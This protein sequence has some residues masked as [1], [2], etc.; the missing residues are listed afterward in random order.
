MALII[1][2]GSVL[3]LGVA[4]P[5]SADVSIG[6]ILTLEDAQRFHQDVQEL[7]PDDAQLRIGGYRPTKWVRGIEVSD[8]T[9]AALGS[10][11]VFGPPSQEHKNGRVL[12]ELRLLID[13]RGADAEWERFGVKVEALQ[14]NDVD[15]SALRKKVIA[16][17][18]DM[19]KDARPIH[20]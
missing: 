19:Q 17:L 11:K 8:R 10:W 16:G 3:I 14:E 9:R 1:V 7:L 5:N 20:K 18:N 2:I 6:S 13:P 4:E 12:L 15:V